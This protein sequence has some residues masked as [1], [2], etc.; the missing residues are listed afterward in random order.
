MKRA[1]ALWLSPLIFICSITAQAAC[2]DDADRVRNE[3]ELELARSSGVVLRI[4][5]VE[6]EVSLA[7]MEQGSR[8]VYSHPGGAGIDHYILLESGD[9]ARS[10]ELCVIAQHAFAQAGFTSITEIPLSTFSET[11]LLLLREMTQAARAWGEDTADAREQAFAIYDR[12]ASAAQAEFESVANNAALFAAIALIGRSEYNSAHN[13]LSSLAIQTTSDPVFAYKTLSAS[14]LSSLRLRQL[15]SAIES[16]QQAIELIE[17]RLQGS[18]GEARREL[19]EIRLMLAEALLS[20]RRIDEASEQINLATATAESEY[21]LLGQVYDMLGYQEI[22]K[23][24]QPGVSQMERREILGGAI[25]IMLAGRFFAES[26]HDS[27]T[28]AAFENNLGFVYDRLGEF[29]RAFTHYRQVLNM[30]TENE[31]PQVYRVTYANLGRLYQYTADYPRSESYYRRAIELGERAAGALSLSRCPLGT[32]L[33]LNGEWQEALGE[34]SL[35]LQQAEQVGNQSY[36]ALARYELSEDF[37]ALGNETAAWQAIS[38]AWAQD[39]TGVPLT[40]QVRIKRLYAWFLQR[41]GEERAANEVMADLLSEHERGALAP[42]DVI[43]NHAMAMQLGMLQ[44]DQKLWQA[45][46]EVAIGLIEQQYEMLE[47][48]R[49]GASWSSRTHDVYVQLAEA[50]VQDFLISANTDSLDSAFNLSERSRAISLRQ[51]LS[52]SRPSEQSN[53]RGFNVAATAEQLQLSMISTIANEH[54]Q[55]STVKQD[56]IKLP[57][58]Y[59]QHQDVLSLYRLQ[60]LRNIPVPAAM[61]RAQIQAQLKPDQA[62]LYYLMAKEDIYVFTLTSENLAVRHVQDAS[63]A[64]TLIDQAR[65]LLGSPNS[66]PYAVLAQL[67]EKLLLE[68]PVL[69]RIDELFVVPHGTLH[70]LPFSALPL[71]G[72]SRYTPLESRFSLQILPSLTTWLMNKTLNDGA[73]ST[74]IAIFADPVFDAAHS[75]Q[76]L[77][78]L[79]H[80]GDKLRSWSSSLQRLQS[81]A[82]EARNITALF[83]LERTVLLTGESASRANLAREDVRNA[84]VLHIATHGYFNAASDD[85]VGIGLSVIDEYGLPDSGFVTL[86]ELFSHEFNNELVLISGCDTAMGRPLAGEGMMGISRGFVAQG[87]KNVISTLWPVSDRASADFMTIFYKQLLSLRNVSLALQASRNEMQQNPNYRHP[88][89]WA[90]YVLTSVSQDQQIEFPSIN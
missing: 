27:V 69:G 19:A 61:S 78:S 26:A 48:E 54:A 53:N 39:F 32:T 16:F 73:R 66:F 29:P 79:E 59:Y 83:P 13:R 57:A 71:P 43:D 41:R 3:Y 63:I 37:L 44:G 67:S 1:S 64:R 28:Q 68:L 33:R 77:A 24:Q 72:S 55:A 25:D 18:A 7:L 82:E 81:T 8:I 6:E 20:Q 45:Q 38:E 75:Q 36:I 34:H 52:D 42:V 65:E 89:Y 2:L 56:Q 74:D 31:D 22:V 30:V 47:S 84:K 17:T 86:P 51:Q 88:F 35:C 14:G 12:V 50:Y 60:G 15:D 85:N 11:E 62:V 9:L 10:V 46:G 5:Q 76:V 40:T 80:D 90:A 58:N 49:L 21:R 87:V 70:A 23:S 4:A